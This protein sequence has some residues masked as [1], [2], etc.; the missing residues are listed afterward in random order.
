M[1]ANEAGTGFSALGN[2]IRLHIFRFLVQAGHE[3]APIGTIHEHLGVPLSTLAHH[4]NMLVK[5]GLVSQQKDGRQVI[6]RANFEQMER[7]VSYLTDNCCAGVAAVDAAPAKA[8]AE[9]DA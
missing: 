8:T 1:D 9:G 5:A 2:R 7:L 4:L 6:C 3:G